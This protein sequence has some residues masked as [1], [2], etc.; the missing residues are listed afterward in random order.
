MRVEQFDPICL[1]FSL[2][3]SHISNLS[4]L[5]RLKYSYQ[6]FWWVD[7]CV[8][9]SIWHQ[10]QYPH[11]HSISQSVFNSLKVSLSYRQILI[12]NTGLQY[13][14]CTNKS[15]NQ[16]S[17][18]TR[19]SQLSESIF[20]DSIA[21]CPTHSEQLWEYWVVMADTNSWWKI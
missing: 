4:L 15:L 19:L 7:G 3:G 11:L 17:F 6:F 10:A 20:V 13:Y 21:Y 1:I 14:T 8:F 2:G 12:R 16:N 18:K 5:L 9:I